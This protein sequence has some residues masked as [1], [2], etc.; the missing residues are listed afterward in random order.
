VSVY[1]AVTNGATA[2]VR[3][4]GLDPLAV[5]AALADLASAMEEVASRAAA[6]EATPPHELPALS[7]P[8]PDLLA[9]D[10]AT[11]EVRLFAS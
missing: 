3:L 4:L 8:V 6:H 1:Q 9:E 11:W 2:G 5:H 10:H 7:A